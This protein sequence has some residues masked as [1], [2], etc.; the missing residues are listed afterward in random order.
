MQAMPNRFKRRTSKMPSS[1]LGSHGRERRYASTSSLSRMM[2][3][4]FDGGR[5]RTRARSAGSWGIQTSLVTDVATQQLLGGVG[6]YRLDRRH[7]KAELGYWLGASGRGKGSA[8]RALKLLSRWAVG[9]L[10][11]ERLETAIVVGNDASVRVPNAPDSS[12]RA[13]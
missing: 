9:E 2:W 11:V 13:S 3:C 1:T 7:N 10:R 12:G 5:N 4:S 6:I 8:T